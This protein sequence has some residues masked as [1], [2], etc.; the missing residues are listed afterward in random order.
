MENS[1]RKGAPK[2]SHR[3]LL[4]FGKELKTAIA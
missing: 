3:P 2:D 4:N 1:Y